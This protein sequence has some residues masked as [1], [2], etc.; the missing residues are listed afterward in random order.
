[1]NHKT[2]PALIL[3][4]LCSLVACETEPA[5]TEEVAPPEV[6][7]ETEAHEI[8]PDQPG[9]TGEW[10]ISGALREVNLHGRL[11]ATT[12]LP[13]F[14]ARSTTPINHGLGSI[15]GLNGEYTL[16]DDTL[17]VAR[18]G[19]EPEFS[20][21]NPRDVSDEMEATFLFGT[22]VGAWTSVQ[23]PQGFDMEGLSDFLTEKAATHGVD[24]ALPFRIEGSFA[25]VGAH[26]VDS[27]ALPDEGGASCEER[28]DYA[29][30]FGGEDLS[31]RM[32][33]IFTQSHTSVIVDHTTFIH[34][35]IILDDDRSGHVDH[36]TI[37]AGTTVSLPAL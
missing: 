15:G 28:K 6:H 1:M 22:H 10:E 31:G 21:H 2:T 14:F 8:E 27:D 37:P 11:E 34:A 7:S 36:L 5:A 12:D 4:I 19:E 35:H 9:W 18:G 17:A 26:V 24:G 3:L 20:I 16:W 33:G 25:E 13:E 23:T 29:Y 32:V 30:Q